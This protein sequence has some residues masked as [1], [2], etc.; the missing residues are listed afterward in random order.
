MVEII[1]QVAQ[2]MVLEA[3]VEQLLWVHV[4][5]HQKVV[6]E[7]QEHLIILQTPQPHMQVV[8]VEVL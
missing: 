7:E 1:I 2:L 4:E 3:V 5:L 6:M 8:A